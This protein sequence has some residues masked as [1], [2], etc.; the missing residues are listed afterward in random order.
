MTCSLPGFSVHGILQARIVEWFA[1]SS[2]RGSSQP[3]DQ[4]QVSHIERGFFTIWDTRKVKEYWSGWPIPSPGEHT[5]PG[6]KLGSPALQEA[7]LP[8]ELLITNEQSEE[9]GLCLIA[10]CLHSCYINHSQSG[11]LLALGIKACSWTLLL[12]VVPS[13]TF[14]PSSFILSFLSSN[15]SWFMQH[16][17][18]IYLLSGLTNDVFL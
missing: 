12:V 3:R 9:L 10:T 4:T 14:F 18:A 1:M 17:V 11:L 15:Y 13:P 2:S 16:T 5:D 7:S 8:A 6:I